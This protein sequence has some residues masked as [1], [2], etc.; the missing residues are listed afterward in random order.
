[1]ETALM[2]LYMMARNKA[3]TQTSG[4]DAVEFYNDAGTLV[5]KKLLTDDGSDYT[6]AEMVSG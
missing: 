1:M 5:F 2:M 3:V 6:E 4:T